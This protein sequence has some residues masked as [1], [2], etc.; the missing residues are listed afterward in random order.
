MRIEQ[1]MKRIVN[2]RLVLRRKVRYHAMFSAVQCDAS[3]YTLDA[4]DEVVQAN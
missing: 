4:R 3:L 2:P 1:F